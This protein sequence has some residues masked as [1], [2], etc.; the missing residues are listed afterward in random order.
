M[1]EIRKQLLQKHA[2]SN[3]KID[4]EAD[5]AKPAE[6]AMDSTLSLITPML[7][8]SAFIAV[9]GSFSCGFIVGYTSPV[10]AE[11]MMK[12]DLSTAQYS[13]FG[14]MVPIGGALGSVVCGKLTDYLGRK[15]VLQLTSVVYIFGWSAISVSQGARLLDLGRLM[16]GVTSGITGYAIPVYIAE[17]TP[18]DLRGGFV[19][20]HVL[21]ITVGV[22]TAF[23]IG[24]VTSWCTLSLIGII[25][26]LVQIVGLFFIP[27]S[28]RWLMMMSKNKEF[29]ASLLCLR[30]DFVDISQEAADIRKSAKALHQMKKVSIVQLFQKKY[31]YALTVGIG[32]SA[33]PALVGL[34]G[35]IFYAS[36]IFDSAGFS[37]KL[38]TMAL[39]LFQLLSVA[40][41]IILMDKC[42]RRPLIMVSA[43]GLCLGCSLTGLAFLFEDHHLLGDFSPYIA[44]IGIL[45]YVALYPIGIGGG[46]AIII[47][48]IFPLNIKW[49]AGSIAAVVTNLSSWIVSYAF[50]F[51]ME[52]SS[53]GTFFVLA[54][55]CVFTL[56]F[57]AKLVPETKG[58]TLEE[59][60]MSTCTS[61]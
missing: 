49:S 38:G 28:P 4:D 58:R 36:S 9:L 44:L 43:A 32:L 23:L 35:I 22:S 57:V 51:S 46:S 18:K 47:S 3:D 21:M 39:A 6:A 52:W 40:F 19:I 29:E 55:V 48:E 53:S 5:D 59:V 13:L 25:P 54:G 17:F 8:L 61:I 41:G 42:G 20:L 34:N 50:N 27:E 33:L 26:G 12:L 7:L 30:G 2:D 45:I 60:H 24:Q 11:I 37:V 15:H 56:I 31:A 14:S 16:L 1:E 10:Q